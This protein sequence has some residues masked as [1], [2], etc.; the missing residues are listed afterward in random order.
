M[1]AAP[2]ELSSF[3]AFGILQ[4]PRTASAAPGWPSAAW[5]RRGGRRRRSRPRTAYR[6]PRRGRRRPRGLH[7][8]AAELHPEGAEERRGLLGVGVDALVVA[9]VQ[10]LL[11][12][13]LAL[14]LALLVLASLHLQVILA[15][16]LTRRPRHR[17]HP[18]AV[19]PQQPP[20]ARRD[21]RRRATPAARPGFYGKTRVC[22]HVLKY[23]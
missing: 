10:F 7:G 20:A 18:A 9:L 22:L 23:D 12:L 19:E 8:L 21:D 11:A 13:V 14:V 4:P 17:M 15:K 2:R 6:V 5:R 16:I 1:R 3:R